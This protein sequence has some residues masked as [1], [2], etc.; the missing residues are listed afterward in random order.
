MT[1]GLGAISEAQA[2]GAQL[3]R[4][5]V[6]FNGATGNGEAST[7]VPLFTVTGGVIAL[8][9]AVCTDTLVG[10]TATVEVGTAASPTGFIAQTGAPTI[11]TGLVWV[12][13]TPVLLECWTTAFG[14]MIGD[15]ADIELMPRTADVTDG[16]LVFTCFWTPLTADGYVVGA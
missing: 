15:G 9:I 3:A 10:A 12:D 16:T 4:K 11:T 14:C 5:T 7:A 2:F 13:A 6:N 8:V 1:T